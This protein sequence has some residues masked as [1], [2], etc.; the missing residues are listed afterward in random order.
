MSD[1]VRTRQAKDG[2]PAVPDP[3]ELPGTDP[4]PYVL[5]YTP[6]NMSTRVVCWLAMTGRWGL[7]VLV[8]AAEWESGDRDV[9]FLPPERRALFAPRDVPGDLLAVWVRG[10]LGCP[11]ALEPG[12]ARLRTSGILARPRDEP[13][14]HVRTDT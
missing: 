14:F 12:T 5:A 10:V 8:T 7:W 9:R 13:L 2:Q 1:T 11:V 3:E 4:C 6:P